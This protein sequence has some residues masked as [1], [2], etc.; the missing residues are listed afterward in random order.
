MGKIGNQYFVGGQAPSASELNAV[1][2]S[3]AGDTIQDVNLDTEWAQR[4]HFSSSNSI[5]S[6]YTFDYD[7]TTDWTTTSTTFTTIENVSGTKSKVTPNYSTHG[8][9][10]VRFHASGLI[11][12]VD[13]DT[14]DGDGTFAEINYNTYAFRLLVSLNSSGSASTVDVSNCTYSFTPKGAYTTEATGTQLEMNYVTFSFSG[15]YSLAS[16]NVIDAVELQACVGLAGNEIN[17]QHN[18]IQVII[19]EN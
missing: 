6:L 11:S 4:K 16:G 7:G 10:V 3:V 9:V 8:N 13:L 2:D 17:I 18:H 5:T 1:Y 15:M 12:T 14:D 19:V